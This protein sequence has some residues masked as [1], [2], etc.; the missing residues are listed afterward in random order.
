[1]K[2]RFFVIFLAVVMMVLLSA[3]GQ[4]G[5]LKTLRAQ[6]KKY[7]NELFDANDQIKEKDEKIASLEQEAQN[8]ATEKDSLQKEIDN[9]K[10][11]N[12]STTERLKATD[13]STNSDGQQLMDLM[14]PVDGKSYI[15]SQSVIFYRDKILSQRVGTGDEIRFISKSQE[16]VVVDKEKNL[17]VWVSRSENGLLYSADKPGIKEP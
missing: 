8:F 7:Q 11:Q 12:S 4:K 15:A 2:K 14:F 13:S 3:C 17:K 10:E 5:E 9:L 16:E 6:V 1:M